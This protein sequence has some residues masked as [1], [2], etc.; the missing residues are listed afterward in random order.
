[1]HRSRGYNLGDVISE[2]RYNLDVRPE[3]GVECVE[4]GECGAEVASEGGLLEPERGGHVL[5]VMKVGRTVVEEGDVRAGD[6]GD[7]REVPNERV[8]AVITQTSPRS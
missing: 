3:G 1:M 5:L 4:R 2:N 7:V 8:P 6:H